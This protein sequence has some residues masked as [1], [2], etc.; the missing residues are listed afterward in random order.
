MARRSI[1]WTSTSSFHVEA[2]TSDVIAPS[3]WKIFSC[4]NGNN[5]HSMLL[6]IDN[7]RLEIKVLSHILAFSGLRLFKEAKDTDSNLGVDI[8]YSLKVDP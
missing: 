7:S 4:Q 2:M 8:F 6:S 3:P 1:D 5:P